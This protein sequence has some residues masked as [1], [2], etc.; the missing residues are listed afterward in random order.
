MAWRW[1]GDKPLSEPMKACLT[2]AYMSHSASMSSTNQFWGCWDV[3]TWWFICYYK[4][5]FLTV[6]TY[7]G[8]ITKHYERNIEALLN[9][10]YQ[11]IIISSISSVKSH[12]Y[13]CN[14]LF[15]WKI[16]A[17]IDP[18]DVNTFVFT[19]QIWWHKHWTVWY[20]TK[21]GSQNFSY[22]I[23]FCTR[24]LKT[25]IMMLTLVAL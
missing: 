15:I 7:N 8:V 23:W 20:K 18:A 21:F 9:V 19:L 4:V 22:Q 1:L 12:H 25:V 13:M 10:K 14:L 16:Q 24:L 6:I 2:V 5:H 11:N 17:L 3:E